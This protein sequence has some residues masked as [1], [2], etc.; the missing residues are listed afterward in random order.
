MKK[1]LGFFAIMVISIG[2]YAQHD[3]AKAINYDRTISMADM[4]FSGNDYLTA[5]RFYKLALK[6]KPNEKY[7]KSI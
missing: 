3:S 2:A 6:A 7:P 4:A 5:K 1:M